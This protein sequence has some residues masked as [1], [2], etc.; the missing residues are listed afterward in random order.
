MRPVIMVFAK[1][2]VPGRVKTRL[3][4]P[5][6][7]DQA[8]ALHDALVRDTVQRLQALTEFDVELHTDI[9]APVWL[10]LT[11]RKRLQHEGDLGLKMLKALTSALDRGHPRAMIVGSDSPGL[12][13]AFIRELLSSSADI[14]IGP[15]EDGGYYAIAATRVHPRMFDAVRWSTSEALA[16]TLTAC[17]AC[18][19]TTALG[20][21]WFDVDTPDDLERL[22]E[23]PGWSETINV[24]LQRKSF[25]RP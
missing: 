19:L 9:P 7:P 17:E 18:G 25:N 14:A 15:A 11:V 2:P 6:T 8:A 10:D 22:R 3:V 12:P 13:P 20:P 4:Q 1:A 5:L 21:A 23:L 16:G 24:C